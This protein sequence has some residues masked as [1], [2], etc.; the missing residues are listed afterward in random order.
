M[1]CSKGDGCNFSHNYVEML[2]R[3][4]KYKSKFCE[5]FP[6]RVHDCDYGIYCSFAHSIEEIAVP[7]VH[8]LKKDADFYMFHFKTVF[9]PF[10]QFEHD[11][12]QCEYCHNW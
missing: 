11:R 7:L 4:N 5:K 8:S 6:N 1:G 3:D 2:Y 9:C 10:N 12:S